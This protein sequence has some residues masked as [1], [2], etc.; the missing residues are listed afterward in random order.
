[1]TAP[2]L[3]KVGRASFEGS[4]W[5]GEYRGT[6]IRLTRVTDPNYWP[7]RNRMGEKDATETRWDGFVADG[8]DGLYQPRWSLVAECYGT[9]REA[10][11]RL[12]THI[13]AVIKGQPED[14]TSLPE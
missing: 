4:E 11:A 6:M 12:V 14:L 7:G 13:D 1:M 10:L 5:Q 3:W 8:S 2:T 9:R